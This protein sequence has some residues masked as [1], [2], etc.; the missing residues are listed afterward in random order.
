MNKYK[1]TIKGPQKKGIRQFVY[2]SLYLYAAS[3]ISPRRDKALLRSTTWTTHLVMVWTS[4]RRRFSFELITV[5]GVQRINLANENTTIAQRTPHY[6]GYKLD[7]AL[8]TEI[9]HLSFN[10]I[11]FFISIFFNS[12]SN[13]MI[14]I[15]TISIFLII[16]KPN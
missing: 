6:D 14:K 5:N 11:F 12:E 13:S 3:A 16:H 1:A 9:S 7:S 4:V 8:I 15:D 2:S 10:N